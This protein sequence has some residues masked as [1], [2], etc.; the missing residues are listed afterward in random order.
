MRELVLWLL[1]GVA[2]IL[3]ALFYQFVGFRGLWSP[4]GMDQAQ[5]ARNLAAGE[6]LT[7]D[8]IRPRALERAIKADPEGLGPP[9]ARVPD[10]YHAPLYPMVMAALFKPLRAF[11]ESGAEG[12]ETIFF[13]DRVVVGLAIFFLLA[14]IGVSY[15]LVSRIFDIKIGAITVALLLFCS[16]LWRFA[17]GGLPHCFLLFLFSLALYLI[18]LAVENSQVGKGSFLPILGA[19][20]L[21]GLM[22]M[23]QWQTAWLALGAGLYISFA[24]KPRLALG[25]LPVGVVAVVMA[26]W[27]WRNL[28]LDGDM[29][30]VAR[31]LIDSGLGYSTEAA[32]MR[33]LGGETGGFDLGS[34]FRRITTAALGQISGLYLMLGSV[35][36][37]PLFFL[38]LLH[39][40]RRPEIASFRWCIL[41]MWMFGL[42]AMAIYGLPG[43]EFDP[44]QIH[45]LFIPI[46]AAYGMAFVSVL[47]TRLQLPED[48]PFAR[49]GHIVVILVLSALPFLIALWPN[50][51]TGLYF[52]DRLAEAPYN[53]PMIRRMAAMVAP[54]EAIVS[55]MPWAVAWYG[56][57]SSIWLPKDN[58]Q[59]LELEGYA[60]GHGE[61]LGGVF[62][63]PLSGDS[64]YRADILEGDFKD[65]SWLILRGSLR[66]NYRIDTAGNRDFP[67]PIPIPFDP[68]FSFVLHTTPEIAATLIEGTEEEPGEGEA[69]GE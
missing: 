9:L 54:G 11:W 14:A 53:P 2:A 44:G 4:A 58:G 61:A 45:L 51:K 12:K 17:Q 34:M 36:V 68:G 35:I 60:R 32:I 8:T 21:F 39:P 67:F 42:V 66:A 62:V 10:T 13:L 47:W 56:N 3:M 24:F 1:F 37:A 48:I 59:L 43:G 18:Y 55:D 49:S 64:R 63:T 52:K 22:A 31:Q 38:S 46:M 69:G 33:D 50:L 30:G 7:T 40:F 41:S 16:L 23:A 29:L 25:L 65:I 57:R 20:I 19:S 27:G 15:L 6:G 28:Q 26:A 5:I